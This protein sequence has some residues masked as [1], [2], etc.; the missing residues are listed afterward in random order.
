MS[1]YELP[2]GE[3]DPDVLYRAVGKAIHCW[4]GLET[5]LARLALE[6]AGIP[7]DPMNLS[8]FGKQNGM[9]RQR[10][11]ALQAA[12]DGFFIR[13]PDQDIERHFSELRAAAE[14][15]AIERHR[16]AHG[17]ITMWGQF[18]IPV[19]KGSFSVSS[20]VLYRWAPPFYGAEKLRADPVGLNCAG[21]EERISQ[22]SDLHNRVFIFTE[23]LIQLRKVSI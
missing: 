2:P 6:F 10:I 19:V 17:N 12:A 3:V 9:F 4:E 22:F 13:H 7:D 23:R 14:N 8:E 18:K 1:E 16:I 21:I 15:L 5:A 20:T 11:S